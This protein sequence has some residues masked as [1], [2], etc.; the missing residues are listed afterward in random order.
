MLW[1]QALEHS[2]WEQC[3]C[4]LLIRMADPD[5][6]LKN[7]RSFRG[8]SM[9]TFVCPNDAV[10]MESDEVS[11]RPKRGHEHVLHVHMCP[12]C[13]YRETR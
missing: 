8:A 4:D 12:E 7:I 9:P 6:V 5:R 3:G 10:Q 2:W 1:V 13:G 11:A